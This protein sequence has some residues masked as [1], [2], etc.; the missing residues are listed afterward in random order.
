M[1]EGDTVHG[2]AA[3]LRERLAGR[4]LTRTD[5]R[6]PRFS[7]A[8]LSGRVVDEIVARGKHLLMRSDHGETI[9]SHLGMDGSWRLYATGVRWHG[10]AF[11]VRAVLAL[12]G[13]SAV[14]HRLRRLE[15]LA[16]AREGEV[17][18]DL[19]PD[20]LGPDWDASEAVRRLTANP[21]RPVGE[22][23]LDQ[24]VMAGPGNVYRSE[25]CFLVRIDPRAPVGDL[26][27]PAE[28]VERTRSLMEA[29]REG[30]RRVTTGDRRPGRELWVYGRVGRPC[31]RC[32]TPVRRI[33][34]AERIAYVCPSCQ[35]GSDGVRMEPPRS[36]G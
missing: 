9:H 14:G 19:G 26:A 18:G 8:D 27:D 4:V 3:R 31:R 33:E 30:G 24:A 6:V 21:D 22:A 11:E 7:T 17:L 29:N 32:A 28:L 1:A 10:P 12:D 23:L 35:G 25:V 15:I 2:T 5:F 16:T 36:P 34:L 20:P 13:W